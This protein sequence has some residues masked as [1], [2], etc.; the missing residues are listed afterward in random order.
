M[1]FF[2]IFIAVLIFYLF[3]GFF[4]QAAVAHEESTHRY[5][6]HQLTR[7]R[8][9]FSLHTPFHESSARAHVRPLFILFWIC[10]PHVAHWLAV[11]AVTQ[12]NDIDRRSN[13]KNNEINSLNETNVL[14]VTILQTILG[15]YSFIL[16][17]KSQ[18]SA[19]NLRGIQDD[20]LRVVMLPS[21]GKRVYWHT[22][23]QL[24]STEEIWCFSRDTFEYVFKPL[25][26]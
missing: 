23:F 6:G 21:A 17:V 11:Q 3:L 4:L 19:H 5:G 7:R 24:V 1:G 26:S 2:E 15:M 12:N 14:T 16:K 25:L 8:W 9:S 18:Q 10:L 22:V 20:R 13:F